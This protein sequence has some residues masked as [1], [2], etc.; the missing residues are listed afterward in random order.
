MLKKIYHFCRN[1]SIAYNRKNLSDYAASAAFFLFLSLIPLL[2]LLFAVLPYTIVDEQQILNIVL[3]YMPDSLGDFLSSTINEIY[4]RSGGIITISILVTLWSAGK[5][6]QSLIRGMNSIN[7]IEE[8]RGYIIIRCMACLYTVIML[9]AVIIMMVLMMFGRELFHI[10]LHY[11][12]SLI[13]VKT[14]YLILRYPISAVFLWIIFDVLY[15]F[16]PSKK[17][18]I[19]AQLPGAFFSAIIWLLASWLFSVY[20]KYFDFSTYGSLATIII[21]MIYM[22]MMMYIMLLGT[23]LNHWM[24]RSVSNRFENT[25]KNKKSKDY[26]E[27]K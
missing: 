14:L 21:V 11:V 4:V 1:F 20:L 9:I 7:E 8:H 10:A 18:K 6:M 26:Y 25:D 15:C 22:Y 16:V 12:P 2:M 24:G 19:V 13:S 23:Y 5:G 3:N 17:Q 27:Y